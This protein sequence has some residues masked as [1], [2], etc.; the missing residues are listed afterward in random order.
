VKPTAA[1]MHLRIYLCAFKHTNKLSV[2]VVGETS[3][4]KILISILMSTNLVIT[5]FFGI[6]PI[7][8]NCE[9]DR[10]VGVVSTF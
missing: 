1:S 2:V 4:V 3:G 7:L 8:L 10:T 6:T 5:S 9:I